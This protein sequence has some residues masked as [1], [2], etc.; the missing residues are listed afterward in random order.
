MVGYLSDTISTDA[1]M[2][3]AGAIPDKKVGRMT[4]ANFFLGVRSEMRGDLIAAAKYYKQSLLSKRKDLAAY[5]GALVG[6]ERTT[7]KK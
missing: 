1:L 5:R 3:V 2:K 7:K 4:E 6:L